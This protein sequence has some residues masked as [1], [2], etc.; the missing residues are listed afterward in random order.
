MAAGVGRR[1]NERSW[2]RRTAPTL[3]KQGDGQKKEPPF[4]GRLVKGEKLNYFF[5]MRRR[6]RKAPMPIT[7]RA[8]VLGSGTDVKLKL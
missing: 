1:Y 8:I 4:Y 5:N 6:A 2:N 7:P 3:H